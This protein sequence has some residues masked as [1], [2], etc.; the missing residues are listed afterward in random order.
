MLKRIL[1]SWIVNIVGLWLSARIFV[2]NITYDERIGAL[3]IAALIFGIVN[4]LIRPLVVLLSLPAIMLTLGLFMLVVNA[5][6]LY[7]TSFLYPS[8]QVN[9]FSSAVGATIIVWLTNY[10]FTVLFT[11]PKEEN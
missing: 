6:M 9:K 10:L 11:R 8:F 1:S 7:V 5:A 2:G 4:A 3:L